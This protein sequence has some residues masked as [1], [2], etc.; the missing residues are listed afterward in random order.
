MFKSGPRFW[1]LEKESTIFFGGCFEWSKPTGKSRAF[2]FVTLGEKMAC[3][4]PA[5]FSV[6]LSWEDQ[7]LFF[8]LLSQILFRV[9]FKQ[10]SAKLLP[11]SGDAFSR[12]LFFLLKKLGRVGFAYLVLNP[13]YSILLATKNPGLNKTSPFL[14][15]IGDGLQSLL[16]GFLFQ[17]FFFV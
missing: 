17:C 11:P 1:G 3:K 14:S 6:N 5:H 13:Q 15:V 2:S 10:A 16:R 7:P 8:R 12:I 9:W 4:Q